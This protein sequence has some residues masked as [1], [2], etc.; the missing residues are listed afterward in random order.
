MVPGKSSV[1]RY[2]TTVLT[3]S[4]LQA[5]L[6]AVFQL[7]TVSAY[8]IITYDSSN[9]LPNIYLMVVIWENTV[10]PLICFAC[11]RPLR[12]MFCDLLKKASI[13]CK[14]TYPKKLSDP[15]PV[16]VIPASKLPCVY[17]VRN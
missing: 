8:L 5:L 10:H 3:A 7:V 12:L 16:P 4:S 6:P 13:F 17:V 2:L 14:K 1:D 11:M 9:V 15:S